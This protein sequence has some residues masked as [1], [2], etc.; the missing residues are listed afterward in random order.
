MSGKTRQPSLVIVNTG[1]GKGKTSAAMGIA[2]RG[3]ARGWRVGVVQFIKSAKWKTGESKLADRLGI[4]W[5]NTGDGWTWEADDLETSARLGREAW[6]LATQLIGAGDH[7]LLVLDEIT[8]PMTLGWID[9]GEVVNVITNRPSGVNV[10]L[11]G[12]DAPDEILAIAD[13]A[14]EMRK[15]KHVYDQGIAAK[16]GIDF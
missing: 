9:T 5:W 6:A 11:T 2:L 14:T 1:D 10:V 3:V 4:D 7:Q 15:I 16:K 8:Y 13:T 12:R